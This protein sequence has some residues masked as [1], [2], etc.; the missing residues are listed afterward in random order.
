MPEQELTQLDFWFDP[1]CPWAW[2]TSRWVLEVEKVRPVEARW[3]VMSLAVLNEGKEDMPERYKE[4]MQTAWGPVR[5]CIAAEQKFGPDVLLPLYTALG[6]RFHNEKQ[7]RD[8]ETI[9]AALAEAG[10]PVELAD[11]AESAEY[12]EALRASHKDGMDRVGYEVGTPV[13]SVDGTSFFGPVVS[14]IPRG[15]DAAR[16]WDGVLLVAKT[17]GFFELKRSRTRDP[18]FD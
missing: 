18:I 13:I 17:D 2:I 7:E 1:L 14:P 15:E 3:H 6:T 4:F 9:E 5:V 12:D 8:R 11:V 10:L 16:L